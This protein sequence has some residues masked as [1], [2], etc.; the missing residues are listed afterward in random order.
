MSLT[1]GRTETGV[2]VNE[3]NAMELSAIYRAI[4]IL[5]EGEAQLPL[6]IG[7]KIGDER[8]P[9]PSHPLHE[10]LNVRANPYM[11]AFTFRS[12][13]Q[14]HAVTWGNGYSE[15]QRDKAGRVV[16]LWPL[17]PDRTWPDTDRDRGERIYRTIIDGTAYTLPVD[18]V[19]HIP[20]LSFDGLTGQGPISLARQS[21]GLSK[22]LESHG[23]RY[24]R[25]ELQSGGWVTVP[26][27]LS[28][29]ARENLRASVEAQGGL[30]NAH[31]IKILEEGAEFSSATLPNDDAQFLETRQFQV[32]EAAR[33]FGIPLHMLASETG[34]TSWG[35]GI[36]Q[37]SL[38]FVRYTLQPWS[39]R[40]EQ[41]MRFK[42]LAESE[43]EQGHYIKHN[44]ESLLRGDPAAR[45]EYY[46]AALDSE[47]G[48]ML[49]D[50]VRALEDLNPLRRTRAPMEISE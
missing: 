1:S 41:E 25:H 21:V 38:G 30:Q 17:L 44:F 6:A 5:A 45:A 15:I 31:R 50:E 22:A 34:A 33:W 27:K 9:D 36:T 24:F 18:R 10:V 16:G 35:T 12:T 43:R 19:M 20:A 32:A 46:A 49:E 3:H 14:R 11:S 47:T 13:I 7:R 42:L 39:I 23:G 40:W 28:D 8:T 4:A 37:I 48:W 29:T 26:G 2:N